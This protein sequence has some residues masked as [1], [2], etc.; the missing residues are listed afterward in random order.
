MTVLE[1]ATEID[2]VCGMSV[3]ME[4]ART[5]GRTIEHQGHSY[6]FCS[7]GC[8]LE[9]R[10]SPDSYANAPGDVWKPGPTEPAGRSV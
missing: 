6:G 7:K 5:D 10:E 4:E 2:P 1:R 3:D 9:F 8:L